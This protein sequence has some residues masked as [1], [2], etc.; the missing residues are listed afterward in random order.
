M[1]LEIETITSPLIKIIRNF[2]STLTMIKIYICKL[3]YKFENLL[4]QDVGHGKKMIL[5]SWSQGSGTWME[6]EFVKRSV[7]DMDQV[8]I[9]ESS[10]NTR[11]DTKTLLRR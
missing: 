4:C 6:E 10:C 11:K 8:H 5:L 9:P 1:C 2:G 3:Q 7:F